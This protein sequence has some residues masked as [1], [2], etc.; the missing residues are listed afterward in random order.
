[1][2]GR[3]FGV[4]IWTGTRVQFLHEAREALQSPAGGV[5][6]LHTLNPEILVNAWRTKD[7]RDLLNL[8]T[9]N[10]VDGVG[11]QVALTRKGVPVPERLCGSDL[12]YDLA[13]LCLSVNRPLY[14]IGGMPSRLQKAM[15]NLQAQFPGLVVEG[16]SPKPGQGLDF[17]EQS[18]IEADLRRLK[19]GVAAVCLGSPRQ[20]QW[21]QRY[22]ALLSE[23]QVGVAGG[24]GGTVDFVSGE[25]ERAPVWVRKLGVEWLFRLMKNPSRLRRQLSALPIFGLCALTGY[26]IE[27]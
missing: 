19:P 11:L 3:V 25:V 15:A 1:M 16:V 22:K 2:A 26:K 18:Q 5:R 17:A 14:F 4:G 27:A 6:A 21:I 23:C 13:A 7:F 24:L 8:G 9:W 20:E 10:T 12:I